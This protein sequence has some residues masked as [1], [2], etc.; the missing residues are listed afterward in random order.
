MSEQEYGIREYN[1]RKKT[2]INS[3]EFVLVGPGELKLS[4][5]YVLSKD[6]FP[7]TI[8]ML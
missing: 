6:L 4:I 5:V 2:M 3:F 7:R 1:S 8:F